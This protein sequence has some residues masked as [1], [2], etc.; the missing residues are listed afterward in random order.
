MAINHGIREKIWVK[1]LLNKLCSKQAV[2]KIEMLGD[3]KINFTLIKNPESLYYIKYIDVMH[4][5]I[6]NLIKKRELKIE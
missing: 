1:Q 2:K 5:H 3:N 4:Y 6:Q